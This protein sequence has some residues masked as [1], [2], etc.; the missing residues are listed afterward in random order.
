M[1]LLKNLL[2]EAKKANCAIPSCNFIDFLTAKS[3]LRVA[4][5]R[6]LPLILSFAQA[7]Q[8]YLDFDE[9]VLIGKYIKSIANVPVNLH[10]D[11]GEDFETI[12]KAV[13]NGF[14]SVMIDASMKSFDENVKLTR[15]VVEYA[16]GKNVAVEAELGHVGTG[17]TYSSNSDNI[18]T[19]PNEAK[20]FVEKTEV[21]AL[22]VSIGTAHGKYKGE[23]KISFDVLEKINNEIDTPL[24]LHGGSSSGDENLRNCVIKGITKVNIYT[25]FVT[26][27]VRNLENTDDYFK[28]KEE[29]KTNV[30]KVL[31]HYYDVFLTDRI[32]K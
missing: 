30:E 7:H 28:L 32:S 3:Y 14:D 13:D 19:E 21:D 11:H 25:D 10:L 22:A 26:E 2:E 18:Y 15:K 23:P 12:K 6:K 29:M 27:A 8:E 31:D 1:Y 9:A 16:H 24:V 17:I 4:E 5:K 20:I